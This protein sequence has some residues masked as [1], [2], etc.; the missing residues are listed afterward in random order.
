MMV[1]LRRI[2]KDNYNECLNLKVAEGQKSF[3][4][5]NVYSLAQ[6][7]VCYKTAYPFA[8]YADDIMVGFVMMGFYEEKQIYT[9]WRFMID[10]RYQKKGYGKN[11]LQLS[12]D[13]LRK[14]FNVNEI[15]LSVE[16]NNIVAE[17]LYDSLGFKRTGELAGE[18]IEM[19][20]DIIKD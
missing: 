6:A 15:F 17:K 19:R 2:N 5:S 10:T 16:P 11:A 1:E 14:E 20:L 18:E 4:A 9:I 7:W 13:Y 8:I 3:V 12:I